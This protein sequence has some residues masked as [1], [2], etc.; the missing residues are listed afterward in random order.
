[1]DVPSAERVAL[2]PLLRAKLRRAAEPEAEVVVAVVG[3]VVVAIG[4]A[5]VVGVVVP[6]TTTID[7]PSRALTLCLRV[8]LARLE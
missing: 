1:M 4:N 5:E 8:S 6:T 3:R 2:A 7:A